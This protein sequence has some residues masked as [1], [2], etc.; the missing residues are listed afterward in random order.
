M[1]KWQSLTMGNVVK[2]FWEVIRQVLESLIQ[3]HTLDIYWR[4]DPDG[5]FDYTKKA[6]R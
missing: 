2:N 6:R 1:Y 4:Y 5:V 3:Y